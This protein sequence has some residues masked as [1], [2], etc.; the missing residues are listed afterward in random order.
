[1]KAYLPINCTIL[2]TLEDYIHHVSFEVDGKQYTTLML[3]TE[4]E[5]TTTLYLRIIRVDSGLTTLLVPG[6]VVDV[7]KR[8]VVTESKVTSVVR[9]AA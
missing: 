6:I 7:Y 1:M 2:Q 9:L 5:D 3:V 4:M 8:L